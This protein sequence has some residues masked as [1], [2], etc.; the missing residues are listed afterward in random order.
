MAKISL[1]YN[2]KWQ[3]KFSQKATKIIKKL[4]NKVQMVVHLLAKE[5]EISGSILS[6][7]PNYGKLKGSNQKFHCHL[8]KGR[9]TYVACWEVIDKHLRYI[10]VY[11]VGTHEN[12]PY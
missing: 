10:E 9:P 8:I 2:I 7:W 11:Y 1:Y 6:N 4:P 3:V 5:L 12:A